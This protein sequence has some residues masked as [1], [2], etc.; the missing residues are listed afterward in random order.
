MRALFKGVRGTRPVPGKHTLKYGGNTS[1]VAVWAGSKILF[2]DAGTGIVEFGPKDL[3][4]LGAPRDSKD[5]HILFSH[6]HYDHI[7]GI[8]QFSAFFDPEAC[9]AMYGERKRASGKELGF[10][11]ALRS[12]MLSPYYPI[13][14]R[15]FPASLRFR[16]IAPGDGFEIGTARVDVLDLLH[17][18]GCVSYRIEEEGAV[19]VYATDTSPLRGDKLECFARF[20]RGADLLIFDAFFEEAELYGSHDGVN[21]ADWGHASWE[22]ACELA[23]FLDVKRLALYHHKDTRTDDELDDIERLA[24][25]RFRGAFCAKEGDL[26]ELRGEH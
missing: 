21:K 6:L 4:L 16:E 2:L 15:H 9:I 12:Q 11:D 13:E 3:D 19:L 22:Y 7:Q 24:R 25:Q 23:D 1:C 8:P 20:T 18:N 26:I 14:M 5:Y 10:E 17:P